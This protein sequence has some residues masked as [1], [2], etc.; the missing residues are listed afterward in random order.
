MLLLGDVALEARSG[1]E[2]IRV[3]S[4]EALETSAT[5]LGLAAADLERSLCCRT[6]DVRGESTLVHHTIEQAPRCNRDVTVL[7]PSSRQRKSSTLC[8]CV[9]VHGA[10]G[11][12]RAQR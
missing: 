11:V 4:E 8:S 2:G 10:H 6:L 9:A 5:L 7:S 3:A 1:S 12:A